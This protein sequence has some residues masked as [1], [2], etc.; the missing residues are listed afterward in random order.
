[1]R[2]V[3]GVASLVRER[4]WHPSQKVMEGANGA[5]EL[6]L[7]VGVSP[8][9]ERWILGWGDSVEVIAPAKLRDAV[10]ARARGVLAAAKNAPTK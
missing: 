10:L 1:L 7:E 9:V 2:F 5:V 6:Q 4:V 3:S 8:E